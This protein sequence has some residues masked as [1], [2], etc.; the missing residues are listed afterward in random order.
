MHSAESAKV[1]LQTSVQRPET[2]IFLRPFAAFFASAS[3]TFWSSQEFIEVRSRISFSGK[4]A[5]SSGIGVA[6]EAEPVSTVV[7]VVGM[8][9]ILAAFGE[10]DDIVL[11]CLA[12]DRLHAE[13]HLRLLVD[14]DDLAVLPGSGLPGTST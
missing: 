2:T 13:G 10:A 3:R 8:L 11:Q 6:G 12:V 4:T 7:I 1:V 14:E 5:S 9:K